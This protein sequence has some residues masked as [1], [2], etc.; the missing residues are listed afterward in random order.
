VVVV[1]VDVEVVVVEEVVVDVDGA[2]VTGMVVVVV[3]GGADVEVSSAIDDEVEFDSVVDDL[4]SLPQPAKAA[5]KRMKG[6]RR[7][8]FTGEVWH[9]LCQ[10]P[11]QGVSLVPTFNKL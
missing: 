2:V 5:A 6:S 11:D 10:L 7:V 4:S 1:V 8:N 3:S 9:A